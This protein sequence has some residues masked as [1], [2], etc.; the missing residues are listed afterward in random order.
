MTALHYIQVLSNKATCVSMPDFV[1]CIKVN[2]IVDN[3]AVLK[4]PPLITM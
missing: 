3:V 2:I 4:I 1:L